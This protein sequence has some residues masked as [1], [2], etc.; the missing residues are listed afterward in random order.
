MLTPAICDC[1]PLC[2]L[3][4]S[5]LHK[6]LHILLHILLHIHHTWCNCTGGMC[7]AHCGHS[8]VTTVTVSFTGWSMVKELVM[9]WLFFFVINVSQSVFWSLFLACLKTVTCFK[10]ELVDFFFLFALSVTENALLWKLYEGRRHHNWTKILHW[11]KF[12]NT[13]AW[14]LKSTSSTIKAMKKKRHLY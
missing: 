11:G 5:F 3:N 10:R 9:D 4:L 6:M 14:F 12:I 13:Y 8:T 1:I 7:S 2:M